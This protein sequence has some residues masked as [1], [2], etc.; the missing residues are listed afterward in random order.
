MGIEGR[1]DQF[2]LAREVWA[3]QIVAHAGFKC[4][5]T[6]FIRAPTTGCV[7]RFIII[8]ILGDMR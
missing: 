1:N 6:A 4:G 7:A 5:R 3:D 8:M 2:K